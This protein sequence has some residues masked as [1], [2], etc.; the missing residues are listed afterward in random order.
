MATLALRLARHCI[1]VMRLLQERIQEVA[2]DCAVVAT[3]PWHAIAAVVSHGSAPVGESPVAAA[4]V[5][6][7]FCCRL[8][9]FFTCRFHLEE[10]ETT[11]C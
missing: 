6:S 4:L 10:M 9:C 5:R 3:Y 11:G 1:L 7:L 8:C 2:C